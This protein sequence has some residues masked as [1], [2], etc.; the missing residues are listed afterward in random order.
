MH[1]RWLIFDADNTLF[2]FDL[3]QTVALEQ[4]FAMLG[5]GFE[6]EHH[7]LYANVNT[8]LWE[9]FERG[10]LPQDAIKESRF[11][12]LS[13]RTGWDFDTA[14][15]SSSYLT[16]LS[17][18]QF[19]LDGALTLVKHLSQHHK[20]II[21]TNGLKEVQRPRFESSPVSAYMQDILV[22][23]ELGVAKPSAGIFDIAFE[24]MGSPLRS[25]VL[26]IGD[27]LSSDIRGGVNY[28]LNTCWFNPGGKENRSGLEP[29]YEVASL[30]EIAS[31]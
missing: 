29:T 22:S 16:N 15:V 21:M 12:R 28:G 8:E 25:E 2:D 20:L 5:H 4:T 23:D 14:K 18:G 27:S 6:A 19:L 10:E 13:E 3:A 9:A 30:D 7:A 24:R 17:K 26:M 11:E 31:L 1:Y